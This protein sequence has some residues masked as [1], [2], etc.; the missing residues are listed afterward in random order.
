V[1]K[2]QLE[3]AYKP[4]LQSL[5]D[6]DVRPDAPPVPIHLGY[7]LGRNHLLALLESL[8]SIGVDHVILNLKYGHRP[9]SEVIDELGSYIVPRF[10]AHSP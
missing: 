2:A 5:Y 6:L 10:T 7:R 3:D 9:A 1:V 8:E 4:F